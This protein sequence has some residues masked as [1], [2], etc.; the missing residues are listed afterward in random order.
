M[1]LKW[2][3][4]AHK[5][6]NRSFYLADHWERSYGDLEWRGLRA[7]RVMPWYFMQ[8]T[9]SGITH[10]YGVRVRPSAMCYWRIN[11]QQLILGCDVR[12]GGRGVDLR[13]RT[14]TVCQLVSRKGLADENAFNAAVSFTRMLNDKVMPVDHV[15]YGA[16]DWYYIYG[17]NTQ[18]TVLRD[19]QT[20]SELSPNA[21]NRPYSVID[22]GWQLGG[23]V[24]SGG[25]WVKNKKFPDFESLPQ[26]MKD[27]GTRPGIW[28]RPSAAEHKDLPILQRE[29]IGGDNTTQLLDISTSEVREDMNKYL[30]NL[31]NELGFELVKHDFSSWDIFGKPGYHF[32]DRLTSDDWEFADNTRSTAE[33]LIDHY[34]AIQGQKCQPY[35][36]CSTVP[37]ARKP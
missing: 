11:T 28:V 26:R 14:M 12:S 3:V 22:S 1:L 2:D 37:S 13:G 25:P 4:S 10:G 29:K 9:P 24:A 21:A 23:G 18:E 30:H 15:I 34:S 19:T 36:E 33:I 31:V 16:N 20:I 7:D 27:M 8:H 6:L 17:Q 35:S 32:H 5:D